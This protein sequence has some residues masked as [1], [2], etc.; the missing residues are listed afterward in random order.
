MDEQNLQLD[1]QNEQPLEECQMEAFVGRN[2]LYYEEK[3]NSV[4]GKAGFNLAA[5]FLGSI[6]AV[7]RRM[8]LEAAIVWVIAVVLEYIF[9]GG[10]SGL[11]GAL[12]FGLGGNEVYRRKLIRLLKK[13]EG[14]GREEQQALLKKKG[15]TNFPA[16]VVFSIV[17][18]CLIILPRLF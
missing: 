16:A 9:R 7:Y 3:W 5:F 1:D 8:Y 12:F 13:T 14:L 10:W 18:I 11:G 2:T 4:P 17:A 15:G 6:W